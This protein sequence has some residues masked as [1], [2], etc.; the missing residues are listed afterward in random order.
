MEEQIR[1]LYREMY[2]GMIRK[3]R[4]I[5]ERVLDASFVLVHMTG[6]QQN[7]QAFIRAVLN[8]TLNYYSARHDSIEVSLSPDGT[9]ADLIGYSYVSAAVFGGGRNNWRLAQRM[10][11]R[12]TADGWKFTH[13]EASTY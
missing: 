8:G 5:L 11:A 9:I 3:D 2:D 4:A 7:R 12:K 1:E 6:M 10:T 13:S